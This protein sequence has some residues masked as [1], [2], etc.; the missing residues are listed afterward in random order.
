MLSID[1]MAFKVS[2]LEKKPE[3]RKPDRKFDVCQTTQKLP[4]NT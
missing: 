1:R 2:Q 3:A 4:H